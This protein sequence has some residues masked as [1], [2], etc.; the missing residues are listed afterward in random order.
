MTNIFSWLIQYLFGSSRSNG[1]NDISL[2]VVLLAVFFSFEVEIFASYKD[3]A[4]KM[5]N[6]IGNLFLNVIY[7]ID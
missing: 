7:I 3:R 4:A 2:H 5:T 6:P 1:K